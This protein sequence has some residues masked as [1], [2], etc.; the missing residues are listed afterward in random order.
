[1]CPSRSVTWSL[2]NQTQ[3]P[4]QQCCIRL[5]YSSIPSDSEKF[6]VK[7]IKNNYFFIQLYSSYI[8][9]LTTFVTIVLQYGLLFCRRIY[10]KLQASDIIL[11]LIYA[12]RY[13]S[14]RSHFLSVYWHNNPRGMLGEHEKRL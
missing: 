2:V 10:Y 1:M 7:V 6:S 4:L 3:S 5:C 12:V 13:L 14:K 8:F 9:E 11:R